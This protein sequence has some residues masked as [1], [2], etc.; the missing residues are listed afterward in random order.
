MDNL[1]TWILG[2]VSAFFAIKWQ[3]ATKEN[4]N[5]KEKLSKKKEGLYISFIKMYMDLLNK[6]ITS[7]ELVE[8]IKD[9]NESILLV[10]SNKVL[11]VY[12]DLTQYSFIGEND[13]KKFVMIF[14]E[15]ILAMREDMG[16][17]DWRYKILWFHPLR[18]WMK[19]I[20]KFIPEK[21]QR[22][23]RGYNNLISSDKK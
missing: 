13:P 16:H 15:L 8:K 21:H 10:A 12:G 20:N 6:K 9:F 7:D 22:E 19:D 4:E 3:S 23:K 1:L 14:G 5:L 2:L 11:L 17:K 18:P